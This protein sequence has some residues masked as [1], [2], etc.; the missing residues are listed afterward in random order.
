MTAAARYSIYRISR[1]LALRINLIYLL[2]GLVERPT[3]R[4]KG[5]ARS[6]Q[7]LNIT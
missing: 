6:H 4:V 3:V 1:R 7:E 2:P 5:L